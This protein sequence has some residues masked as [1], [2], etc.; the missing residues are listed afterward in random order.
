[1]L[2][3]EMMPGMTGLETLA[4]IKQM[5]PNLPVVMVT[6]SEEEHIM[7]EAIGSKI[8][9]YLIKPINPSQNIAVGEKESSTT[10]G[11]SP[12]EPTS[13]TSRNSGTWPCSINDRMDYNEWTEVYKK[14]IYWELGTRQRAGQQ[15]ERGVEHAEE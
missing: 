9:D 4:Q 12:N 7:E 5:R 15:H 10:S 6:K 14:L 3:D 1:M 8:A 2:L 13:A 11:W